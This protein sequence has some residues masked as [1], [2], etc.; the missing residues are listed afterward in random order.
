[1]KGRTLNRDMAL[2]IINRLSFF[3]RFTLPEK[4]K[5]VGYHQHFCIFDKGEVITHE[6]KVESTFFILISGQVSVTRDHG[7][8]HL[9]TLKPEDFFGEISFLTQSARTATVT[10]DEESIAILVDNS[11][12]ITLSPEIREKIKDKIIEKL[13][14]RLDRM[15]KMVMGSTVKPRSVTGPVEIRVEETG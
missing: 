6:G 12:L 1:M 14:E 5:L 4:E 11:L 13:A 7:S 15:N 2:E 3:K 9:A 8:V 10:A